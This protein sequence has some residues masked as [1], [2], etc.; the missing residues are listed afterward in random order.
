MSLADYLVAGEPA[1]PL[2]QHHHPDKQR[3]HQSNPGEGQGHIDAPTL[4]HLYTT[5]R[6][7]LQGKV[8]MIL[9]KLGTLQNKLFLLQ[10]YR[11]TVRDLVL[12]RMCNFRLQDFM[13]HSSGVHLNLVKKESKEEH[14]Q[15]HNKIEQISTRNRP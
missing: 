13:M 3:H 4:P 15:K 6:V 8:T 10:T 1:A 5:H 14:D 7:S 9:L 2:P 12:L 11:L